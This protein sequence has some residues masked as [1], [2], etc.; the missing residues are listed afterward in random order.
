MIVVM[1]GFA[2]QN[3]DYPSSVSMMFV[4]LINFPSA[5]PLTKVNI[6]RASDLRYIV[7]PVPEIAVVI[8]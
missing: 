2:L 1:R 4:M 6:T 5:S 3:P 8:E 7:V